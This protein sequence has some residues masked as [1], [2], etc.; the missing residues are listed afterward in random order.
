MRMLMRHAAVRR[1]MGLGVRMRVI[2]QRLAVP[3]LMGMNDH[4]ATAAALDTVLTAD[5][6]GSLAFRTNF[7]IFHLILPGC[8]I[9][10]S[11]P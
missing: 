4:L 10:L 1:L 2:M 3:M 6:A 8:F 7:H 9:A 11:S 5:L